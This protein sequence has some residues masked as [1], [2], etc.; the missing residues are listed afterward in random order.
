MYFGTFYWISSTIFL[1]LAFVDGSTRVFCDNTDG[2]TILQIIQD[3]KV[4]RLIKTLVEYYVK[5]S[6]GVKHFWTSFAYL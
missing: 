3:Y 5:L 4:L 6:L 2:Q 1:T